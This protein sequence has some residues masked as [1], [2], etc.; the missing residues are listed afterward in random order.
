MIDVA[1]YD[2]RYIQL[3]LDYDPVLECEILHPATGYL[4]LRP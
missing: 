1:I 3:V 2:R 4:L